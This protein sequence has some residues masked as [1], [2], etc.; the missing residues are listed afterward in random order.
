MVTEQDMIYRKATKED[1]ESVVECLRDVY[2]GGYVDNRVFDPDY[3]WEAQQQ[4]QMC[5]YVAV[6][7]EGEVAGTHAICEPLYFQDS[8][9]FYLFTVKN[10]FR[11]ANVAEHLLSECLGIIRE[12]KVLSIYAQAVTRHYI[13]QRIACKLGFVCT[14]LLFSLYHKDYWAQV[15]SKETEVQTLLVSTKGV[16]K[17][18]AG[19][20]Y[21]DEA[22]NRAAARCYRELGV[23][24]C[25]CNSP[26]DEPRPPISEISFFNDDN[27]G[28]LY[29]QLVQCGLDLVSRIGEIKEQYQSNPMQTRNIYLN[30]NHPSAIYGYRELMEEGYIF[31]GFKPLGQLEYMILFDGKDV[32]YDFSDVHLAEEFREVLNE[33]IFKELGYE[34]KKQ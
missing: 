29:I 17:E 19:V 22:R 16:S 33:E 20:L 15:K 27:C 2:G 5:L 32:E 18:D 28:R 4:N 7:Q 1:M 9:L 12:D 6:T 25:I 30:V 10:K 21:L 11:R 8:R 14:G 31:S 3:L 34:I 24:Y 13:S 26:T 23:N